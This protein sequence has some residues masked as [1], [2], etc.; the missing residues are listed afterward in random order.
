MSKYYFSSSVN[1]LSA[2]SNNFRKLE[3]FPLEVHW[4]CPKRYDG[5]PLNYNE[6]DL[7]EWDVTS[8]TKKQNIAE[9]R[10]RLEIAYRFSIV[11]GLSDEDIAEAE[12]WQERYREN[13]TKF[14]TKCDK[15]IRNYH[16]ARKDLI[17]DLSE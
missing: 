6:P 15:C 11:F 5:D 12:E 3:T 8:E 17:K 16:L 10:K 4:F 13:L 2:N 1:R 7:Q 9:G 14:L